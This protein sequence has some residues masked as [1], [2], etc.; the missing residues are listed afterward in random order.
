MLHVLGEVFY[1][2]G[3]I[4]NL[5][6]YLSPTPWASEDPNAS[7]LKFTPYNEPVGYTP[8]NPCGSP[9]V[10]PSTVAISYGGVSNAV[11]YSNVAVWIGPLGMNLT[12]DYTPPDL[13]ERSFQDHVVEIKMVPSI[14]LCLLTRTR[15]TVSPEL[16]SVCQA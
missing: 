14:A 10:S 2:S 3:I 1:I 9:P 7:A 16:H 4:L 8:P 13:V 5:W 6:V 12:R 15:N 11:N